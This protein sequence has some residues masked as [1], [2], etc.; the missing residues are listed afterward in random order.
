MDVIYQLL[1]QRN[2][3][4]TTP[5]LSIYESYTSLL[6]LTD[7]L[8]AKLSVVECEVET[9]RQQ[10][11]DVG[12]SNG[13]KG[14]LS[15]SSS[16]AVVKSAMKNES[17]LRDKLELLQEEVNVKLKGELKTANMLQEVQSLNSKNE[18]LIEKLTEQLELEKQSTN[19][20]RQELTEVG[21][22][23]KLAEEQNDKLKA[24]VRSLQDENDALKQENLIFE[25]RLVAEK[26]KAVDQ[27]NELTDMAERLKTEVDTLRSVAKLEKNIKKNNEATKSSSWFGG[28]SNKN[29][30]ACSRCE[31]GSPTKDQTDCV[32]TRKF[33]SSDVAIVPSTIKQTITAHTMEGTCVRY[34]HSGPNLVAT[35]SSD[36][37]VKVWDTVSGQQ[38]GMF[39][40]STGHTIICCDIVGTLV[41]G[42]G[43]DKT[44]RVWNVRT[45]RMVRSTKA[46]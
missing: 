46:L 22:S 4:E 29:D 35:S 31:S 10:L 3:C 37:S 26:G 2:D 19:R 40:G 18:K 27:M 33:G 12:S 8:Q 23:A 42:G 30:T 16:S 24:T 28:G 1:R 38:Q 14:G 5:F 44:C 43:S 20:L 6:N 25:G 17:R 7:S 32:E 45:E 21:S 36:S 13:S 39:R 11:Q 15:S 9:L 41:V 34:D